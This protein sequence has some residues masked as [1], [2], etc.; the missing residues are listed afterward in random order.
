MNNDKRTLSREAR[1]D[2]KHF[3]RQ[4]FPDDEARWPCISKPMQHRHHDSIKL[5]NRIL[6]QRPSLRATAAK[7]AQNE[8][9]EEVFE[10][11]RGKSGPGYAGFEEDAP[12]DELAPYW[13]TAYSAPDDAEGDEGDKS[14]RSDSDPDSDSD[15]GS[16]QWDSEMERWAAHDQLMLW[17]AYADKCKN[18]EPH[19]IAVQLE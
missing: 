1:Q 5:A 11:S 3:A 17:K 13:E 15:A 9:T 2:V 8:E 18:E 16:S 12:D 14:F 10:L 7:K 4:V 19:R 6:A